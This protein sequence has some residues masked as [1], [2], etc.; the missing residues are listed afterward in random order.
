MIQILLASKLQ[1][2]D[3]S[4]SELCGLGRKLNTSYTSMDQIQKGNES[5]TPGNKHIWEK[6]TKQEHVIIYT[7]NHVRGNINIKWEP[8]M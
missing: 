6:S 7:P 5:Y 2:H 4:A 8:N 1:P 3:E